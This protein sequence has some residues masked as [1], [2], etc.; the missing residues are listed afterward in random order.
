MRSAKPEA[1]LKNDLSGDHAQKNRAHQ[2]VEP[3][4]GDVDPVQTASPRDPMF[5]HQAADDDDPADDVRDAE[6]AQE[7]KRQQQSA[8]DEVRDERRAQGVLRPPRHDER[9][10]SLRLVELVILQRVDDVEADEPQHHGER[11]RGHLHNFQCGNLRAL[12]RQPR[13][14]GREREREAEENV[15]VIREPFRDR[16]KADDK[17]RD[18]RKHETKQVQPITGDEQSGGAQQPQRPRARQR[19]LAGGQM[20]AGRAWIERVEFAVS[21]SVEG[22][23]ARPGGDHRGEN[24]SERAPARPAAIV[25][26]GH[27]HGRQRERQREDRVREAHE[28]KPFVNCGEHR[29]MNIECRTSNFQ[30]ASLAG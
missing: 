25:A 27:A 11:E 15:C 28:G 13:A 14:D 24:Q 1:A 10:Q 20:P 30:P 7:T 12:H 2:R 23:R 3:K 29:T 5:H 4:K 16:V 17:Q 18:G 9:A 21:D 6:V 26:R 8:H 22:H 19:N